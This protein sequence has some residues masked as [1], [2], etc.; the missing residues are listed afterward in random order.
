[1][2]SNTEAVQIFFLVF[3]ALLMLILFLSKFLNDRPKVR[4]M[5]SEPAM[6]LLVG[7][8][9]S[10]LISVFFV[11]EEDFEETEN[12]DG[13]QNINLKKSILSFPSRVFFMALLPPILFNSGYELQRELFYRHFGPIALFSCLGTCISGFAT[14]FVL[15]LVRQAGWLGDFNP[16]LMELLTFG[17]LIAATDT[18]SVVGILQA[19]KVD[20]RTTA[21]GIHTADSV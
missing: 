4:K 6:T 1:M 12:N 10:F 2:L 15:Y 11:E 3:A 13:E 7:M 21:C 19:K 16:T 14:G 9:F 18:V 20:V 8:L 5:L 17:A